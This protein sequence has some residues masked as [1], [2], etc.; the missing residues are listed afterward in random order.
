MAVSK[1]ER[2]HSLAALHNSREM[3]PFDRAREL[4]LEQCKTTD[5][6]LIPLSEAVDRILFTD[7]LAKE[8]RPSRDLSSRDGYAFKASDGSIAPGSCDNPSIAP[9]SCDIGGK[10][11]ECGTSESRV[12]VGEVRAGGNPIDL[13][14]NGLKNSAV[15][16]FTG[17]PLPLGMDTVLMQE[18][19][20]VEG[21]RLSIPDHYPRDAFVRKAGS[22][23]QKGERIIEKGTRLN[24]GHLGI[25]ASEGALFVEAYKKPRVA[26]FI[27]GDEVV[28]AASQ[29]CPEGKVRNSNAWIVDSLIKEAGGVPLY[30]GCIEDSD[31]ALRETFARAPSCD[32]LLSIGG[33]SVGDYDYVLPTA[34]DMGYEIVFSRIALKPGKPTIF[35]VKEGQS[36]IGLPGNPVSCFVVFKL[37]LRPFLLKSGGARNI[38][39]Q[40]SKAFLQGEE[41]KEKSRRYFMPGRIEESPQGQFLAMPS[42]RRESSS[43][44]SLSEARVLLVL[45]EGRSKMEKGEAVEVVHLDRLEV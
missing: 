44:S 17:A 10:K 1:N 31:K 34:M 4:L 39:F 28:D 30:L 19:A 36:F 32:L 7:V 16:I 38:D 2:T 12:L 42:K 35:G 8:D 21:N 15:R 20:S 43:L 3:I 25:L 29:P 14:A 26:Y 41:K 6:E 40:K 22:D 18:D 11:S 45:P 9:G 13:K 5:S 23:L 27:S 33:A 37:L 24:P